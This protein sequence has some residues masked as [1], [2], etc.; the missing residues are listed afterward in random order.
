MRESTDMI[1]EQPSSN[2]R[3][4]LVALLG[5]GASAC[6]LSEG[7]A[8]LGVYP[9]ALE[10]DA[11]V[12]DAASS[13]PGADAGSSGEARDAVVPQVAAD[14]GPDAPSEPTASRPPACAST[15]CIARTPFETVDAQQHCHALTAHALG[16]VAPYPVPG[17]GHHYARFTFRAPTQGVEYLRSF[18]YRIGAVQALHHMKLYEGDGSIPEGADAD[19]PAPDGLRLVYSWV[20]GTDS[21][22]LDPTI[23]IEVAPQT[24][25]TVEIHYNSDRALTDDSGFQLCFTPTRPEAPVSFS[26]LRAGA[27]AGDQAS[28]SCTPRAPRSIQ[29]IAL[30]PQV[31]EAGRHVTLTRRRAGASDETLYDAPFDSET[32]PLTPLSA[33]PNLPVT[34][35]SRAA[36]SLRGRHRPMQRARCKCCTGRR[37]PW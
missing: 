23:G 6:T 13:A 15:G 27:L 12:P 34:A 9:R 33:T 8:E 18:A 25:Y 5:L 19:G 1:F 7:V 4:F 11:Q 32:T 35:W 28:G 26:Q 3:R 29:L 21:A 20:P 17:T 24:H 16:S 37:G 31:A 14:A 2:P 30:L 10:T 36:A 22:Y